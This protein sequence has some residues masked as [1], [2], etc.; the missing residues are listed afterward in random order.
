MTTDIATKRRQVEW[1]SH[2]LEVQRFLNKEIERPIVLAYDFD[3][4]RRLIYN[5]A[6]QAIILQTDGKPDKPFDKLK[7]AYVAM[8]GERPQ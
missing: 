5:R 6:S 2:F 1:D 7:E 4:G 8:Y 3:T